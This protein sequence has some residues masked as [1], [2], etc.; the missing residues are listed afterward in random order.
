M[1]VSERKRLAVACWTCEGR[2]WIPRDSEPA[3]CPDCEGNGE[4]EVVPV[5][6]QRGAV[7]DMPHVWFCP[8][9]LPHFHV[10]HGGQCP[11][12]GCEH[13]LV[14]YAPATDRGA[15]STGEYW[16]VSICDNPRCR[17]IRRLD[18]GDCR[19]CGTRG[20]ETMDLVPATA[21][22]AV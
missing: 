11:E 20:V 10:P 7:S 22:G 12:P 8:D 15:V 5:N 16:T 18:E 14:E 1:G 21:R 13:E 4:L 17:E 9:H 19:F 6:R 2:G 3:E